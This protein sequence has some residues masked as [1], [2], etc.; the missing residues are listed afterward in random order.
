MS[1]RER[2]RDR[3]AELEGAVRGQRPAPLH[4]LLEVLAVDELED[5]VLLAV[6]LAAVDHRDDVGMRHLGDRPGLATES[7]H[8]LRVVAVMRM[9]QLQRDVALQQ[10]VMS[11]VDARHPARADELDELVP[12]CDHL[13]WHTAAGKGWHGTLCDHGGRTQK[14]PLRL[15]QNPL[16]REH[17]NAF[18]IQ[19]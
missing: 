16:E 13:T 10:P 12:A 11:L 15:R 14:P 7:L 18:S 6:V 8:V 9:E 2:V 19:T 3:E 4:H 1:E 17:Q 5:D